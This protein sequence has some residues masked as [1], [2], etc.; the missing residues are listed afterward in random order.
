MKG[1]GVRFLRALH[2]SG[3]HMTTQQV[4]VC[5]QPGT[6]VAGCPGYY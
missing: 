1:T 4:P 2:P 5:I 6:V 3:V